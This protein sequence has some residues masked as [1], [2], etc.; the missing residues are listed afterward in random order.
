[1]EIYGK[2]IAVLPIKRKQNPE[3]KVVWARQ[4]C[5]IET[6]EDEPQRLAFFV[7]GD[8]DI[9]KFSLKEGDEVVVD[10]KFDAVDT[11]EF[12]GKWVNIV[13]AV[14]IYEPLTFYRMGGCGDIVCLDCN[15]VEPGV[16]SFIHGFNSAAI[17]RQCPVCGKLFVEHNES[18]EYHTFGEATEDCVC[19][20]CKTIVRRKSDD[21]LLNNDKPIFC[22]QC[23]S[24]HLQY[25]MK[26]I[27]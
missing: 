17:G 5:V 24:Y 22:P 27:T 12:N 4:D 6:I 15:Y 21:I 3:T 19:P 13:Q 25:D 9:A 7:Y 2:I 14:D 16:V 10:V 1:M 8:D 11:V 26:Y 18:K 20:N 23:K